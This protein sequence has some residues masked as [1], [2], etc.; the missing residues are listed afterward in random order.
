MIDTDLDHA[1]VCHDR[2]RINSIY[3]GFSQRD[4]LDAGVIK[5]IDIVPDYKQFVRDGFLFRKYNG[6]A[7][8]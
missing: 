6:S 1:V 7:H 8:S 2:F 4:I 3:K 5:P